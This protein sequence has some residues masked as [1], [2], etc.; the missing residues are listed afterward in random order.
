[1]CPAHVDHPHGCGLGVN[2]LVHVFHT[3]H[4]WHSYQ[5]V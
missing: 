5:Q 3:C 2:N 4:L 1:V